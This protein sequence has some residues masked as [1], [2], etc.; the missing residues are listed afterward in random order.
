MSDLFNNTDFAVTVCDKDWK[1][2]YM[3]EKSVKTFEKYG[4]AELIGSNL[5]D[6]HNENSQAMLHKMKETVTINTYTIE[7]QGVKKLIH[8]TPIIKNGEFD[9]FIELSIELP[10]EMK[11]FVRS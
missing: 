6:C 9:G 11:H 5:L 7:K 4:G 2:I 1:I 3:N 10:S 8:Q